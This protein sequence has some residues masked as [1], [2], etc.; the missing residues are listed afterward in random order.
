MKNG[1]L[2]LLKL[3]SNKISVIPVALKKK[4]GKI[5]NWCN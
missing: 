3:F 1:N 2:G 5:H 4:E